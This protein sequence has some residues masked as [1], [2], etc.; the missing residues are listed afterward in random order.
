MSDATFTIDLSQMQR[1]ERAIAALRTL[2]GNL[3]DPLTVTGYKMIEITANA[4]RTQSDPATGRAWKPTGGLALLS[5]AGSGGGAK[6]LRD[7]GRLQQ[8]LA[9]A[10]RVTR[11][12]VSIGSNVRYARIHQEGGTIR[13][14]NAKMLAIPL[15]R[16]AGRARS[17]REWWAAH[18]SRRPFI[19]RSRS[20]KVFIWQERDD[21][22]RREP[23]FLLLPSARIDPRPYLGLSP[24]HMIEIEGIFVAAAERAVLRATG[25]A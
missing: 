18:E 21:G 15:T 3:K 2:G 8:S 16:E 11:D 25:G 6:T 19:A 7:T 12:T 17:A 4:F 23:V 22:K 5:R 10:P 1:A 14:R 13:P 20:G 24:K 9:A